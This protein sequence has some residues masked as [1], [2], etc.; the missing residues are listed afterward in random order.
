MDRKRGDDGTYVEQVTLDS[1]LAVFKEAQIPVLTANEVADELGC[2]RASAYNKLEELAEQEEIEKKKVG[3]RAVVYILLD[4]I[5]ID[6]ME[7]RLEH[8]TPDN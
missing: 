4:R 7:D 5:Y 6:S 2:S 3:G 1:V 8:Q